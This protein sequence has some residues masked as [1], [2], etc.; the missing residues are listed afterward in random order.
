MGS[1]A[2]VVKL[3]MKLG[4]DAN[5]VAAVEKLVG[6]YSASKG[7]A[8]EVDG[9][10]DTYRD[11][12]QY[13]RALAKYE[14][15][16]ASWP[17]SEQAMG[18]QASVVKLYM[19]LGDDANAVAAV[20]KLVGDYS[21]SKGIVKVVDNVADAYREAAREVYEYIVN[22]WPDAEHAVDS[23]RGVVRTSLLLGDEA[24]IESSVQRLLGQFGENPKIAEVLD[25]LGDDFREHKRYGKAR[26]LYQYVAEHW[27][28]ADYAVNSLGGVVRTSI[29]AGDDA[30][31]A[32]ATELLL[33]R[34]AGHEDLAEIVDEVA[35]EYRKGKK[36]EK[37]RDLYRYSIG[38]WPGADDVMDSK[39]AVVLCSISLDDE[40]NATGGLERLIA[41]HNESEGFEKVALEIG[42]RYERVKKRAE[43]KEVYES[44]VE[45]CGTSPRADSAR[46]H[47][48]KLSLCEKA[49]DGDDEGVSAGLDKI[50]S[51]YN[52]HGDLVEALF[53]VGVEYY[54]MS[55]R[56]ED[57]PTADDYLR[58]KRNAT[59]A[60]EVWKRIIDRGG[61]SLLNG[62]AYYY[63]TLEEY[64]KA[65]DYLEIVLRDW[66]EWGKVRNAKL[67]IVDH[68]HRLIR[69]KAIGRAEGEQKI[70]KL[71]GEIIA[72]DPGSNAAEIGKMWFERKANGPFG[73]KRRTK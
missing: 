20:E 16:V 72:E 31:A 61:D 34:Y 23:Q 60:V 35:D 48:T 11:A 7:I 4:D 69:R 10:G 3:Y 36:Y 13:E 67:K 50:V 39:R 33:E 44:I 18:S 54:E 43:A 40:P 41:D 32:A 45:A 8:D 42:L 68:Y 52:D 2:S 66:P 59:K 64:D 65:I 38:R 12:E 29:L 37:A 58:Y 51:D 70:E 14:Q 27:P 49:R 24:Y 22:T 55:L 5:A 62:W 46:L 1:Q 47:L 28:D 73:T 9:I 57:K 71:Y 53:V 19:R 6:D 56:R 17:D 26:E 63:K 21:A 25:H 30:N 15:V